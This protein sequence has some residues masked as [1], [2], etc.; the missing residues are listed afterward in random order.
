MYA[1]PTVPLGR[2]E[3]VIV[4]GVPAP[5]G[6]TT[7]LRAAVSFPAPFVA[8][9]VKLDVPAAVGVPE[10]TPAALSVKP[11]GRVPTETSQVIGASP[12]AV[13]VALYALPS[14]ALDKVVVVIVGATPVVGST[15]MLKELVSLPTPFVALTV[16]VDVPAAVGVPEITPAGLSV[17]PAGKLPA[18]TSQVIVASP[19]AASVA[20][21]ALPSVALDKAVVVIVGAVPIV[22]STVM[23]KLAVSLPPVFVALTV[24]LYV[25][26]AV[27]VPEITPAGLSVKP[28]GKLPAVISQVIGAVPVAASVWLYAVP[29]ITLGK[30]A[31]VI[32]GGVRGAG[33][34]I[35]LKLTVSAPPVFV[36]LT[37]KVNVPS[38]VGV[39]EI[40]PEEL[41][42]KPAGKLPTVTSQVNGVPPVATSVWVYAVPTVPLTNVVVVMVGG[43]TLMTRLN[44]LVE[45]PP[46]FVA[47]TVKL[48]VPDDPGVPEI[49]PA[50]LI[51]KPA[52]KLPDEISQ[53]IGVA[54]VA[55]SVSLYAIPTVPL[56][57]VVVVI[58]GGAGLMRMLSALE[59]LLATFVAL[60]VKLDVPAVVGVPVIT[61]PTSILKPAGKLPPEMSQVIGAVPVAASVA[62]YDT[63]TLPFGNEVVVITGGTALMIMLSTLESLLAT[64]VALTVKLDVPAAVGVPVITPPTSILKPAGKLPPEISQV[65]GAVPVAVTVWL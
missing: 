55:A 25:P 29:A 41:R 51:V 47:L 13:S 44:G 17:K 8:L 32:T 49:T 57:K 27:G 16:K 52:G 45:G 53:V 26:I 10:I 20:L 33:S 38:A 19:V 62:L 5:A 11:T 23:L 58:T 7:M 22:G 15:T 31:V 24:K 64:F 42:D 30:E 4:G 28:T 39:P 40:T 56:G 3:V 65:I 12:V 43:I 14:V 21:Y 37:V 54:P 36:A 60:T 50:G 63:P 35:M 2:V 1:V 9:T 46:A 6:S 59:S 48:N 18:E 61:P 34:T